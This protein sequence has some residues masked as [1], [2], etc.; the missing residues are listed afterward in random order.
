M[1]QE[2]GVGI[3]ITTM[4]QQLWDAECRRLAA[5]DPASLATCSDA[6]GRRCVAL[7]HPFCSECHYPAAYARASLDVA[8][9]ALLAYRLQHSPFAGSHYRT[10]MILESSRRERKRVASA[11]LALY[12][13]TEDDRIIQAN[14]EE[15]QVRYGDD[16]DRPLRVLFY[17]PDVESLR[18]VPRPG[19]VITSEEVHR[20]CIASK[21]ALDTFGSILAAEGVL[22]FCVPLDRRA[23][24]DA[25]LR[26]GA[27]A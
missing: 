9:L 2:D 27:P 24:S 6:D 13:Y 22:V 11:T 21:E 3:Q 8:A 25:R 16:F 26:A 19:A 10:I 15:L 12:R 18:G 17:A 7:E 5:A 1:A 14:E 4:D 23:F 20:R